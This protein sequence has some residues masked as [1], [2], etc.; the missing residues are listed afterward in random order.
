MPGV[1]SATYIHQLN[2]LNPDGPT[3]FVSSGDDHLRLIKSSL[4]STLPRITGPLP[5]S[6]DDLT[7]TTYLADTGAANVYV[8]TFSPVWISYVV[9]KGVLFKAANTNTESSTLNVNG[10]GPK[11]IAGQSGNV[12]TGG[13]IIAGGIYHA[14]YDGANFQILA[15]DSAL[16]TKALNFLPYA[17]TDVSIVNNS[18]GTMS[19][20]TNSKTNIICN[21]D[22]S[23]T[24]EDITTKDIHCKETLLVDKTSHFSDDVDIDGDVTISGVLKINSLVPETFA[25][26]TRI[27]FHQA[28]APSGWLQLTSYT[29]HMMRVIATAG[30][31]SGG[32]DSAILNNKVPSH[33]HTYSDTT[34]STSTAHTHTYT[35]PSGTFA[36][37]YSG[38]VPSA[39]AN[40]VAGT[41]GGQSAN[42]T[43]SHTFSGSVAA[44][45]G[46]D[47]WSPKY[48]NMILCEKGAVPRWVTYDRSTFT[49]AAVNNG[50]I[51][52]TITLKLYNDTF[53][54]AIGGPVTGVTFTNTPA[55]LT[56]ILTKNT[57]TTATLSFTGNA[58]N[59]ATAN[60]I[61]NFTITLGNTSF[62]EGDAANVTG[63]IKNNIRITFFS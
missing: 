24:T 14:V 46:A 33:T 43:H 31:G 40:T 62:T 11:T 23:I 10:L 39:V 28:A 53:V 18:T 4:Q 29:D 19:L 50:S 45:A 22:G 61:T 20:K 6:Q 48:I 49:E 35:A 41:T 60:T 30:G 12:L 47:N 8:V 26:G 21:K 51:T 44:N 1:E 16:T 55:G 17:G 58:T 54:G 7:N 32:T 15:I 59:H 34:S 63:R 56:A 13:E 42:A 25:V 37:V 3:D 52:E 2:P 27:A 9:G 57:T 38:G 36:A 5:C